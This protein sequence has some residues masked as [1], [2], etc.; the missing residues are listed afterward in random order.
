MKVG[1]WAFNNYILVNLV[2]NSNPYKMYF[3]EILAIFL[4]TM[5]V[6][7]KNIMIVNI[8]KVREINIYKKK[9]FVFV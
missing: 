3:M 7:H 5:Y 1:I 8:S 9:L 6:K 4:S 2:F